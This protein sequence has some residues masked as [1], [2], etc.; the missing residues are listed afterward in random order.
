LTT[1]FFRGAV[2]IGVIEYTEVPWHGRSDRMTP[3]MLLYA[4]VSLANENHRLRTHLD[5]LGPPLAESIQTSSSQSHAR[6]GSGQ[7]ADVK[8]KA[9][10]TTGTEG[11][12]RAGPQQRLAA[13]SSRGSW[14]IVIK[15]AVRT[16][17]FHTPSTSEFSPPNFAEVTFMISSTPG[18]HTYVLPDGK[19]GASRFGD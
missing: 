11:G 7:V 1:A 5:A 19:A 3:N 18:L 2:D 16:R 12:I 13:K 17:I 6:R 14:K 4:I 9:R 15:Y 10:V 8:G